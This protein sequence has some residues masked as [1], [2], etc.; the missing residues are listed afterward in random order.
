[1]KLRRFRPCC[2]SFMET[3]WRM[4]EGGRRASVVMHC[5]DY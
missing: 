3:I 4:G 1:L 5:M 2:K